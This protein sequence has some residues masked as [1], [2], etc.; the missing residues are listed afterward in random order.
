MTQRSERTRDGEVEIEITCEFGKVLGGHEK[1]ATLIFFLDEDGYC[2]LTATEQALNHFYY[3]ASIRLFRDLMWRRVSPRG[4]LGIANVAR[5]YDLARRLDPLV[6]TVRAGHSIVDHDGQTIGALTP[7][8]QRASQDIQRVLNAADWL[9]ALDGDAFA[10][11]AH[12]A[13]R[14][15]H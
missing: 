6:R 12:R 13:S 9:D 5:L 10:H 2:Q 1:V 8:A 7:G 3:P 15:P 4:N 11:L 14:S